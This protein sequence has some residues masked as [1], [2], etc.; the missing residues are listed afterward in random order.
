[1]SAALGPCLLLTS[2]PHR[3]DLAALHLDLVRELVELVEFGDGGPASLALRL[4]G[5]VEALAPT[6]PL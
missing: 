1:V 2:L 3:G 6:R 4:L 5:V